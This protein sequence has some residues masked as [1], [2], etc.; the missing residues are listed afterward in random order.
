MDG[1][2]D[3]IIFSPPSHNA[4]HIII[5]PVC[6]ND[7]PH[8]TV[9]QANDIKRHSSHVKI[10]SDTNDVLKPIDISVAWC[11]MKKS[12]EHKKYLSNINVFY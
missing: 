5:H 10:K 7:T 11:E 6:F 4:I 2:F 8:I 12:E 1:W 3:F 9:S